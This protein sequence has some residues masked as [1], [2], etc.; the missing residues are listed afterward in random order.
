MIPDLDL[1]RQIKSTGDENALLELVN[2]HS[3]IYY[4]TIKKYA[5]MNRID[6]TYDD[7][8][9]RKEAEIYKAVQSFDE[10]KKVK[11]SSWL[12]NQTKYTCL[13]A[14][15]KQKED[16]E[17]IEYNIEF[18][19][20]DEETPETEL[21]K[22]ENIKEIFDVLK[23]KCRDRVARVFELKFFGN[24]GRGMNFKEISKHE[25]VSHQACQQAFQE[26]LD[27]IKKEFKQ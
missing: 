5:P 27:V 26:A 7:F 8:Y 19:E 6:D 2:R 14:R 12:A 15:Q 16:P 22:K 1:V 20:I 25:K 4:N 24:D 3:G 21:L 18:G 17:T 23:E 13:S 10:D 11:F 9:R